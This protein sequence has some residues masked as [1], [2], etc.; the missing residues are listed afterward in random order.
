[1]DTSALQEAGLTD[2]ET[3]TYL[4]LLELGSS[5]I[6]PILE[7]SGVNR[8]IIYRI[9][10]KLI[11]KGLVSYITKEKTKYY[12]AAPPNTL[13]DYVEARE[14][15]IQKNKSKIQEMIP[16]L[17]LKQK[18]AKKSEANMYEGFR[19]LMTA[20]EN[21]YQKLKEGDEVVLYGLPSQ[22][23]GFHHA[24][25][26]KANAKLDKLGIK[27]KLLYHP[28]VTDENLKNRN[29]YKLCEARRMPF[30]IESPSWVMIY[31]D[32]VLIA[33]PQGEMPFAFEITSQQVADSFKNYFEWFW[34]Q[35]KP[36]NS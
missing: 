17:I 29:I 20:Y 32:V 16:Q 14:K 30:N 23:P 22:Q 7:K 18:L 33:I 21:R 10:E 8:S 28:D 6:G 26:K 36:F 24:Y 2:G 9:L 13:L 35:S 1:M 11:K 5:T 4:A 34:K 27:S 25:W 12:Q 31:K 19:G 15:E 3:R